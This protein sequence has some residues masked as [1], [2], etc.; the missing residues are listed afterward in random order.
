MA[1]AIEEDVAGASRAPHAYP[2][3]LADAVLDRIRRRS[4]EMVESPLL[5]PS[6]LECVLSTVFQAG[7]LRDE[8]RPVSFRALICPPDALPPDGTPPD[9]L[10]VVRFD[11]FRP[12]DVQEV[13][14]L[15]NAAPYQRSL[16]GIC[17]DRD[18]Q[19]GL[20]GI[21]H[22]G[23]RWLRAR[24]GGR[25]SSASLPRA[26]VVL[27][28]GPGRIEV[29]L[30]DEPIARLEGGSIGGTTIDV[31]TSNWLHERFV[32]TRAELLEAHA[33][34]RRAAGGDWATLDEDLVTRVAQHMI[35]QLIVLVRTS[36]HGGTL[37]MIP[38]EERHRL[39]GPDAVLHLKYNI[40][41]SEPRRR[42]QT[43]MIRM[44][45]TVAQVG[46]GA[47]GRPV[48]WDDYRSSRDPRIAM[49]VEALFEV[50]HLI[51]GL[52]G[53]D[54]AVVMTKRFELLGFGAEIAGD[55]KEV[56]LVSRALDVEGT[57]RREEST[58]RVGTRHRSA[59]RLC[60]AMRDAIAIIVSQD[61]GVRFAC[62]KDGAVTDWHHLSSGLVAAG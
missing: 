6:R 47:V 13:R 36:R 22:S 12:F 55:L 3:D 62:W 32:D 30:G 27:A 48:G 52:A 17:L 41:D 46:C 24:A 9:G 34:A 4:E 25:T 35:R 51:A 45:N 20:W 21:V 31:F 58:E 19:P 43:L 61:G 16:L 56:P 28:G 26:L 37:L 29:S 1:R 11:R 15:A 44:M 60:A 23:A 14:R 38:E 49:L 40:E 57:R 8:G 7:L 18:G 2:R 5:V 42:F 33:R 54:G 59:Y 53:V 39:V 10:H 50:S